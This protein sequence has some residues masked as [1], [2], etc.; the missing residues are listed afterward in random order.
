MLRPE[1]S[2]K[3]VGILTNQGGALVLQ[4]CSKKE[5]NARYPL[6]SQGSVDAKEGDVVVAERL[7]GSKG[8]GTPKVNVTRVLG[9]K[10]SP[11]ILTL[12][13]IYEQG[14]SDVFSQAA[15]QEAQSLT[16]PDLQGREDL[17]NVPLVTVDGA[18]SRDFDDAIYAEDTPD[19]GKHLIV[20]IADVSWY[21]RPGSALDKE[22]FQRGNSTYFPDRAVAMLPEELSNG[23]C[24]LKPHEDRACMAYHLWVDKDGNLTDYKINRALMRSAARLT[25]VQL[26]AAKD[27]KPDGTTAPLMDTVVKPLYAAYDILKAAA[28]RRGM[29][30]LESTEYKTEV[31]DKG[32][33]VNVAEEDNSTSHDVIA[34]FMI[35]ANVAGDM[36]L[37][38]ANAEAVHR[39]HGAPPENKIKKLREYLATVGLELPPR[40]V[41]DPHDFDDILKQAKQMPN[42]NDVVKAI[43]R[44]Q[45]KAVYDAVNDG[46]FGLALAGYGHHTSPIRRYADLINHRSLVATFNM[47]AGALD[48]E[49]KANIQ[50]IAEHI[51]ET[52]ILSARAER[53]SEDRFAAEYLSK[54][55]GKEFKGRITG[56]IG[57]AVFV[58]LSGVGCE[59]MLPAHGLP[60]DHYTFNETERTLT[61]DHNGLVFKS[62]DEMVVRVKEANGLTGAVLLGP[63]NDNKAS[64]APG[65][66]AKKTQQPTKQK[67]KKN[68]HKPQ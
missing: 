20:A 32:E 64:S 66:N 42:G 36:A 21:V 5:R 25:Y 54:N 10:S 7:S 3:I 61:G 6:N 58:R 67:N 27:G 19:G 48:G 62:G 29:I 28:D 68:G 9:Q 59:G 65:Q 14:L 63:A 57:G 2:N 34:Q 31:N 53:A 33:I 37:V 18:D 30:N 56:V 50:A 41:T 8:G 40:P 60:K 24:S 12:I 55:I 44:A 23:L 46:H 38:K 39:F 43:A 15:K 52:E 26:Q 4:P 16:V 13:S 51:T 45:S 35:L 11:G 17:R 47:G 49:Q 22:A 1:S